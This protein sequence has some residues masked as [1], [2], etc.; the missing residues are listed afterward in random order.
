MSQP[1]IISWHCLHYV[2]QSKWQNTEDF[3]PDEC[4]TEFETEDDFG[5]WREGFCSATCPT[6]GAELTQK[7]DALRCDV[8]S[9]SMFR[10]IHEKLLK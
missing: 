5:N 6:C 7:H 4:D 3:E 10:L 2:G 8:Y 9:E 1:I